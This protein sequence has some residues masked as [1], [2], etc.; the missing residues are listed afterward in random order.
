MAGERDYPVYR[1]AAYGIAL[2]FA[3]PGLMTVLALVKQSDPAYWRTS[4]AIAGY[5]VVG[6]LAI[7]GGAN[8]PL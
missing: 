2:H 7:R 1:K 3:L 4:F 8:G 5:L 6:V